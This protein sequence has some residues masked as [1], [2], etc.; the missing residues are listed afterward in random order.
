MKQTLFQIPFDNLTYEEALKNI[1]GFLESNRV[2]VMTVINVAKL[3]KM[4]KD[5]E[6]VQSVLESDLILADGMPIVWISKLLRAPLKQRIA[7]CDLFQKLVE[8]GQNGKYRF[9]LL[10]ATE[11]VVL[12]VKEVFTSRYPKSQIVG[13]RNGYF[14]EAEEPEIAEM[15]NQSK[16]NVLFLGF[17]SP[18]KENYVLRNKAS[19]T[20]VRF[21][22]GVGGSFD[23]VAGIT[24]RAP[25][26]MQNTG[27]E[28]FYRFLQE[29]R[30]MFKRYLFTNIAFIFLAFRECFRSKSKKADKL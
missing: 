11:E 8:H 26:W 20:N 16:A 14:S 4:Q 13:Y 21:I 2:N 22:Q 17:S 5:S 19:F 7:G 27:L 30:R 3:V 24:K 28:W 25:R 29:P 9:F 15:I 23:I 6:L 10:G 1:D 18:K 12:K